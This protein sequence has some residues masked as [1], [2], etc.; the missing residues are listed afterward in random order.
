MMSM[1]LSQMATDA[2]RGL[3]A[4]AAA[5]AGTAARLSMNGATAATSTNCR[6]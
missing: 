6:L 2:W 3:V 1:L 5:L 4:V